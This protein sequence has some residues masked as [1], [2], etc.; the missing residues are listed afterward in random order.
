MHLDFVIYFATQNREVVYIYSSVGKWS[1]PAYALG[2][3]GY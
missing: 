3:A 2:Y 1:R